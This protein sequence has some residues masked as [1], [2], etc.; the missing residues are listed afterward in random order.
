VEKKTMGK[1]TISIIGDTHILSSTERQIDVEINDVTYSRKCTRWNL[2]LG[3][4]DDKP[5]AFEIINELQSNHKQGDEIV[6]TINSSGGSTHE[7]IMFINI[8][9]TLFKPSEIT[10]ILAPAGYSMGALMFVAF[11]NSKRYIYEESEIMFHH[12][13]FGTWGKH[14]EVKEQ[15][16]FTLEKY[17]TYFYS[18]LK[19]FFKKKK[20]KELIEGKDIWLDAKSMVKKGIATHKFNTKTGEFEEVINKTTNTSKSK[21]ITKTTSY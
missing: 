7:G 10:T 17:N 9:Q 19:P 20:I 15:V 5:K 4:F 12:V 2:L 13:S 8:I 21:Q 6:I 18:I 14:N 16:S 11:N 3:E 1:E